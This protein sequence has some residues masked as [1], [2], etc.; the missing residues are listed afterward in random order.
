MSKQVCGCC[1]WW[2][3]YKMV[4]H[5]DRGVCLVKDEVRDCTDPPI[6]DDAYERYRTAETVEEGYRVTL[7]N[8]EHEAREVLDDL[9]KKGAGE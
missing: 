3:V 5:C 8:I 1:R 7:E 6:C 9:A 4:E 2:M